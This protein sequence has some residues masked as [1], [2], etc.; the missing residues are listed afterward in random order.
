M[1]I[2]FP[3]P[4]PSNAC[5][6]CEAHDRNWSGCYPSRPATMCYHHHREWAMEKN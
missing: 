2:K 5:V 1:K 4:I 6:P 3:E